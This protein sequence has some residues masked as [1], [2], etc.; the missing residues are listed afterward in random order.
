MEQYFQETQEKSLSKGFYI[1]PSS[2]SNI[3]ARRKDLNMQ[4]W[5]EI[6][7]QKCFLRNLLEVK[8][9]LT[10]SRLENFKKGVRESTEY[11]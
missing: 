6:C 9:H 11:V 3:K 10:K 1:R 2:R 4:K 7:P 8:F 5:R